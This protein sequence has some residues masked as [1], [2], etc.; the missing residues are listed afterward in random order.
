MCILKLITCKKEKIC[1]IQKLSYL[2]IYINESSNAKKERQIQDFAND[3][4]YSN[5]FKFFSKNKF[6]FSIG[7]VNGQVKMG[8]FCR[9]LI[10]ERSI[11]T[12]WTDGRIRQVNSTCFA[13]IR[14]Y[15]VLIINSTGE[16]LANLKGE[17]ESEDSVIDFAV[18]TLLR[19]AF[20]SYASQLIKMWVQNDDDWE[21]VAQWKCPGKFPPY[22]Q[23]DP[24]CRFLACATAGTQCY[25]YEIHNQ[26]LYGRVTIPKGKTSVMTFDPKG[27]LWI[28][29]V[30]GHLSIV[31]VESK[32]VK[33][34]EGEASHR[35]SVTSI[36]SM[37]PYVVTS[38]L[39]EVILVLD[40]DG[41]L[42][43]QPIAVAYPIHDIVADPE[44]TQCVYAATT[45]GV[46]RVDIEKIRIRTLNN[47]EVNQLLY[48]DNLYTFDNDGILKSMDNE[49]SIILTLR[50]VYDVTYDPSC[51]MTAVAAS[52]NTHIIN[53]ITSD[54]STFQLHGHDDMIIALDSLNGLLIS[55]SNDK[56][57]RIWSLIE[58]KCLTVLLGHINKVVAVSFLPKSDCVLTASNE[59]KLWRPNANEEEQKSA[60]SSVIAHDEEVNALAVSIDGSFACTG[61]TDKLAKIWH[62]H[63]DRISEY[64]ILKGHKRAINCIAFSPVEKIVVTGSGDHSIRIWSVED[65]SCISTFT[66]FTSPI[67]NTMF[68]RNGLQL[69]T[70]E[71]S[72]TLKIIRVKTGVPDF[73]NDSAHSGKIWGM[74]DA[75]ESENFS[76]I[77]GAAD[78]KVC[79]W[80]DNTE[81][82]EQKETQDRDE[83]TKANQD[84]LNAMRNKEFLTALRLAFKL[85]MPNK[86]RIVVR[87]ITENES[88]ALFEYFSELDDLDDF[89]Q[90]FDYIAK[91]T[92]NSRWADDATATIAAILKV[93][94]IAFF[95]KNKK[96]FESKID[97]IIP[98]LERH[99]DRLDRLDIQTYAID[100]ILENIPTE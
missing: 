38:G 74:T 99:Q 55:G 97:A 3:C 96:K 32:T 85:R 15:D 65:G 80:R 76:I 51:G 62:I 53:V 98:Y 66:E 86:L 77:T 79:F 83:A 34:L 100:D 35:Q 93:K 25:I 6:E 23:I 18:D 44:S 92:T 69:A 45:N 30:F 42:V 40:Q 88:T 39:D 95:V 1:F 2:I 68:I 63:D 26:S 91:W 61:S 50:E 43:G 12:L 47:I 36:V 8:K 21:I 41:N 87:E 11:E 13:T 29:D 4:F 5:F 82:I 37:Y 16:V 58:K 7:F 71:S 10:L 31:N 94:Q 46:K 75:S 59:L 67:L 78:G 9:S 73:A 56:T 72:G 20:T 52:T 57:A 19:F 60:L 49:V 84:L 14:N 90:W 33:I 81:E 22:L 89:A 24:A 54:F 64:R 27:N 48:F 70:A 17:E 28:G